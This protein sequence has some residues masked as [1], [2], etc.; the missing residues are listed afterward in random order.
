MI[1]SRNHN[2][3]KNEK[4]ILTKAFMVA[5]AGFAAIFGLAILV[6]FI[7][8][9]SGVI[10]DQLKNAERFDFSMYSGTWNLLA[11]L[12]MISFGGIMVS[13]ILSLV[14]MFRIHKSSKAFITTVFFIYITSQGVSFGILFTVWRA[15]ELFGIFGVA[16][17][18]F[19]M[20][21]LAG[22]KAKDLSRMLPFLIFGT[23]GLMIVGGLMLIFSLTG[24]FSEKIY[25]LYIFISALLTLA[26]IAFDVNWIKRA[27][28]NYSGLLDDDMEYRWVAFFG[29]RLLSDIISLVWHLIRIYSR[30]SKH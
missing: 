4:K 23:I 25:G 22:W 8:D 18:L 7:L 1:K 24:V 6:W 17:I 14:W 27:S 12:S 9:P 16:S 21:A 3:A 19:L 10:K 13:S 11:R 5:G 20:M 2:I 30:M 15:T 26:W 29:F 28:Q